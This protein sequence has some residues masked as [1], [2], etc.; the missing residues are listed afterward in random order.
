MLQPGGEV[1]Q[2]HGQWAPGFLRGWK[3]EP[4]RRPVRCHKHVVAVGV[5]AG[6][7]VDPAG[8]D[9]EA[10]HRQ[11]ASGLRGSVLA[12]RRAERRRDAAG[13]GSGACPD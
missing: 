13:G 12:V 10:R 9:P 5:R 4:A 7:E 11:E 3:A 6:G 1:P 8:G 2:T